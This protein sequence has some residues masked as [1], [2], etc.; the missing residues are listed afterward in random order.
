MPFFSNSRQDLSDLLLKY[1]WWLALALGLASLIFEASEHLD[2]DHFHI[3]PHFW[4]EIIYFVGLVPLAGGYI[5]TILHRSE[6]N[7]RKLSEQLNIENDLIQEMSHAQTWDELLQILLKFPLKIAPF[8]A[9]IIQLYNSADDDYE[10]V[11]K[12]NDSDHL[13]LAPSI[14][15][16]ALDTRNLAQSNNIQSDD[17]SFIPLK[18]KL[19]FRDCDTLIC[20]SLPL[21]NGTVQNAFLH[22]Y[23]QNSDQLSEGQAQILTSVAPAIAFAIDNLQPDGAG[24][25]RELATQEER[26]RLARYLHDSLGQNLGY[27]V[28]KLDQLQGED[29]LEELSAVRQELNQMH[30]VANQAYEQI[31]STLVDLREA[32]GEKDT[33]LNEKIRKELFQ[34][35][36]NYDGIDIEVAQTGDEIPLPYLTRKRIVSVIREA[37]ANVEKHAQAKRVNI[38]THWS[39]YDLSVSIQDDGHGFDINS[40]KDQNGHYGLAMMYERVQEMNGRLTINSS[41]GGG[42]EILVQVPLV[43]S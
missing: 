1:R 13:H 12:W 38:F 20:Y 15:Q 18:T 40:L 31:R 17:E 7:K 33:C 28:I 4:R 10:T 6:E 23:L 27:L 24:V 34:N 35:F 21:I 3:D 42:T 32:D 39:S 25:V 22:L 37:V 16:F 11:A 43:N 9:T 2:V 26:K 29:L 41:P 19:F 5:L 30:N 8:S 14:N 36:N